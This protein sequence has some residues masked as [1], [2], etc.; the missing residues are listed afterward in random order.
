VPQAVDGTADE[1][2]R[3]AIVTVLVV[4]STHY[5]R[6]FLLSCRPELI[7]DEHR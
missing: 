3:D 4:H 6:V 2:E 1:K 7:N 5:H